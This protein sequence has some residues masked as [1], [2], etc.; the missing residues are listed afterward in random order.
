MSRIRPIVAL[1]FAAAALSACSTV[2][3]VG[4][5][6]NPFDNEK[7]EA[8][9][10][11]QDG[12]ISIL[13]FEQKLE[14]DPALAG[15]QPIL[16]EATTV[17]DWPQ[18]GGPADNAPQHAAMSGNFEIAWRKDAG[19]GSNA[20]PTARPWRHS[21]PCCRW[22]TTSPRRASSANCCRDRFRAGAS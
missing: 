20:S 10:E 16:P 13:S 4:G 22:P 18:P 8:P 12:R 7:T 17:A 9:A 19:A 1:A 11:P 6:L 21:A 3:S 5:A 2:S 14:V 15:R